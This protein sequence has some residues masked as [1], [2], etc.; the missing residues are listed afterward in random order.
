MGYGRFQHEWEQE[1]EAEYDRYLTRPPASL[2]ADVRVRQYGNYYQIWR[3]IGERANLADAHTAL[4]YVLRSSDPYLVRY[5]AASALLTLLR[6]DAFEP[7]Q[8]AAD[9]PDRLSSIDAVEQ[10]VKERLSRTV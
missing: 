5:H 3:A 7:A 6:T 8:L 1:A 10:L 2:L 9:R 4:L